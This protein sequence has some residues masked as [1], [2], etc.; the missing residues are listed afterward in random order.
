LTSSSCGSPDGLILG[1]ADPGGTSERINPFDRLFTR[2]VTLAIGPSGGGK[3][4]TI[5]ALLERAISQGMRGWIV[6]RSSTA[7]DGGGR[8]AGHYDM[9]LGL[10][11]GSARVQ[12]G[13]GTGAVICPWDVADPAHVPPEKEQFLLIWG[14]VCQGVRHEFSAFEMIAVSRGGLCSRLG[15]WRSGVL[16]RDA[17]QTD[18]RGSSAGPWF[19]VGCRCLGSSVARPAGLEAAHRRIADSPRVAG[20]PPA[21]PTGLTCFLLLLVSYSVWVIAQQNPASSRATATAISVRR[22]ALASR[23]VQTRCRRFWAD[24]A[25]AVA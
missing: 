13:S 8:S 4:V 2:H 11:P 16:V 7:A 6:D 1:F 20:P 9:L 24:Q 17:G 21:Q 3:T 12:V 10:I 25:T 19:V 14:A 18:I 23:R 15:W 5:N 22:L